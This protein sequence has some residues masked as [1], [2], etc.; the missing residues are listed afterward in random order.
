MC[1][2]SDDNEERELFSCSQ[3][4]KSHVSISSS[5]SRA[6]F[7]SVRCFSLSV[8]L[9]VKLPSRKLNRMRLVSGNSFVLKK[10]GLHADS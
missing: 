8:S 1:L 3:A 4:D 2:P 7:L 6:C 5:A 10:D 9:S